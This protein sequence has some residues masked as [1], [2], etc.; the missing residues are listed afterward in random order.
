MCCA[1]CCAFS[2]NHKLCCEETKVDA[3]QVQNHAV[4]CVQSLLEELCLDSDY[5]CRQA[6]LCQKSPLDLLIYVPQD[7]PAP[8]LEI[9]PIFQELS[10]ESVLLL[11]NLHSASETS[12][13]HPLVTQKDFG[14]TKGL[15]NWWISP[16]EIVSLWGCDCGTI[17]PCPVFVERLF[18]MSPSLNAEH[19]QWHHLTQGRI[20]INSRTNH[21]CSA[22]CLSTSF[23]LMLVRENIKV[24]HHVI[25][26]WFKTPMASWYEVPFVGRGTWWIVALRRMSGCSGGRT[27][28][29][30]STF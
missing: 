14:S 11:V 19:S 12:H 6:Q 9:L 27:A 3:E 4:C 16:P 28:R 20:H 13:K 30:W 15:Q 7:C 24:K 22:K 26:E 8:F 21:R 2:L 1:A 10:P 29:K 25:P 23:S 18:S 17:V 5:S